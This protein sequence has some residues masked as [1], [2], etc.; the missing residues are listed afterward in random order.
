MTLRE[1][2]LAL[3]RVLLGREAEEQG[4]LYWMRVVEESG[5]PIDAF[6]GILNSDD[7]RH[8]NGQRSIEDHQKMVAALIASL[9][10]ERTLNI[11]D[12]GA[13]RLAGEEHIYQPLLDAGISCQII[14][15]DPLAERLRERADIESTRNLTLLPFAV[16]DGQAH[17]LYINNVDSTSSLYPLNEEFVRRFGDLSS[18]HTVRTE[19]IR[20]RRLDDVLMC[21]KVDFLKLDIQGFELHA[22]EA[23][24]ETLRQTAVVHCEVEF[25]P[26]YSNQP[27]FYQV[28]DFLARHG[29]VFVDYANIVRLPLILPS[30]H[31]FPE[32][33]IFGDG[34]FLRKPGPSDKDLL[35]VQSLIALLVYR[36]AGIAE[37]LM[38]QAGV[39]FADTQA[40]S[41]S[42]PA[43]PA[44]TALETKPEDSRCYDAITEVYRVP[45]R[46]FSQHH[47]EIEAL[48]V[49]ADD[50]WRIAMTA[51]CKDCD[52]IE[53]VEG[54]GT[55]AQADSCRYQVMHNG[56]R[57]L[58][59]CYYGRWMTE[60]IR[61]LRGH[62]EP[63]EERVFHEL[64][65]HIG[66]GATMIE[67]GCYWSYYSLWFHKKIADARNIMVE[68]DPHNLAI[69]R[70]NFAI[71]NVEG[72][73]INAAAGR[74][75][76]SA[77][78][79]VC[80]SDG[81]T[82][83]IPCVC[84][85][86]LLKDECINQLD[87]LLVDTQ[88][89]ELDVLEGAVRTINAGRLRFVL[90]STHHHSISHDP[91]LHQRCLDLLRRQKAHIIAEHTVAESYS[92]DG[93]I[94]ASFFA[95]DRTLPAIEISRNRPS[96]SL[97]RETEF[98]LA[99]AYKELK[100][101]RRPQAR[102]Q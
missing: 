62:H 47:R 11:V 5:N 60:L 69:G 84:V 100:G 33:M 96:A 64:L 54:A 16:G 48:S 78:P 85:D 8:R 29:F 15:F 91:I 32:T 90:L 70:K 68:P 65:N 72:R 74:V 27:L 92:G 26:I 3:Y 51:A 2:I 1:Y 59:D 22:L 55:V 44:E 94:A 17:T 7:Y 83:A 9:G 46:E 28:H 50:K 76:T 88:G 79:F 98:D 89:A 99:E 21:E 77:L 80:E 45:I 18:L 93:L 14:G 40:S 81:I 38:R 63:Q 67:L 87:M 39:A 31:H 71:N 20:T 42:F 53:K 95:A 36:K 52:S 43:P 4:L 49:S 73:F 13:Q 75:S 102:P 58:E 35:V 19:T 101:P 41:A 23:G 97:F 82:R 12:V 6:A 37:W 24:Q 10:P 34:I 66:P 25:N 30:G 56:I 57:V 61:L 86:D